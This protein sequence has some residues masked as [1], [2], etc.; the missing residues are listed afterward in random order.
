MRGNPKLCL[1]YVWVLILSGQNEAA[2]SWLEYIESVTREMPEHHGSLVSAQAFV[3]RTK[4]DIPAT[5]ELS[6]KALTLTAEEDTRGVLAIN[7][8]IT[9]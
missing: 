5:I 4:G 8:G 6:E 7:L 2:D 9:Y 1:D 3:A